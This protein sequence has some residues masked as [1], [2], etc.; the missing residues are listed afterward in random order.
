[1]DTTHPS[2]LR[3]GNLY[4]AD[5][6][7]EDTTEKVHRSLEEHRSLPRGSCHCACGWIPAIFLNDTES[8][9]NQLRRHQAEMVVDALEA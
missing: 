1:M 9:R 6:R 8:D 4:I 7:R 3:P 2:T 5:V